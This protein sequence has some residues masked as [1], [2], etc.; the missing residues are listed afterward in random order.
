MYCRGYTG[1]V[2]TGGSN[3]SAGGSGLLSALLSLGLDVS[4]IEATEGIR[5]TAVSSTIVLYV[6]YL[7]FVRYL[8]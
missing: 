1:G 2:S 8:C 5:I 6:M 7:M 3:M 4:N